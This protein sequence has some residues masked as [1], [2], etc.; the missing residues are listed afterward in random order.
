[1]TS[2]HRRYDQRDARAPAGSEG[3]QKFRCFRCNGDCPTF[4]RKM[5][6]QSGVRVFVCANCLRPGD[7]VSQ[8]R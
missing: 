5:V 3:E 8:S 6:T 7:V 4:G 2:S 1:M